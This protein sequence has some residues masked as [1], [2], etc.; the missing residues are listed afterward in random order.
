M[1]RQRFLMAGLL[2]A[3]M[4]SNVAMAP[5]HRATAQN[6][7]E[8]ASAPK[9]TSTSINLTTTVYDFDAT[10]GQLLMR[11]DDYNGTGQATYTTISGCGNKPCLFSG[12]N[13]L[14]NWHLDLY[15]QSVRTLW[16]TPNYPINS[17]QPAGPPAGYYWQ[18]VEAYCQCYDQS[19][20]IVPF[21]NLINGSNN[22]SLGVDFQPGSIK[23]KLVMSPHLP[24]TGPATGLATVT[25]NA[26]NSSGQC[27]DWTIVPNTTA[28]AT[29][30][31][32]V[33]NL[34]KYTSRGLVF[35]GQYYNTYR[36][37]ATNP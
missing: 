4:A 27:V 2:A 24:A 20:N 26:V 11:S 30:V 19:G 5:R 29:N 23:Y 22:C 13:Y 33:A 9:T 18:A 14:G 10:G 32:T 37:H 28:S 16:I 7:A 21:P 17:S 6:A 3:F 1:R 12:I 31:P 34:Y 8:A 36:I 35:I 25:C 15:N